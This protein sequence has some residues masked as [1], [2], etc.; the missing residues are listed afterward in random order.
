MC[1]ST[2]ALR[3]GGQIQVHA[4]LPTGNNTGKHLIQGWASPKTGL[5]VLEKRKT[6]FP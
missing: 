1:N 6:Y 4:A 2:P 5:G 3:G